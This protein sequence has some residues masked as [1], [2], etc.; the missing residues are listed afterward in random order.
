M[1]LLD[2]MVVNG[3]PYRLHG[4][5]GVDITGAT[6]TVHY[7]PPSPGAPGTWVGA[8]ED[9][10]AGDFLCNVAATQNNAAGDWIVWVEAVLNDVC[11]ARTFGA[12]VKVMA[13]GTVVAIPS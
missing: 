7:T 5:F 1:T 3:S 11:I 9:G 2:M 4:S 10:T 13:E 6:V 12:L 8:I